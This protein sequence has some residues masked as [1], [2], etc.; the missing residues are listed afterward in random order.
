MWLY[1]DLFKNMEKT[2]L[3]ITQNIKGIFAEGWNSVLAEGGK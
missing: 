1:L 2:H 3:E